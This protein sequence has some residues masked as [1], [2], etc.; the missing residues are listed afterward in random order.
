MAASL[1][2][3]LVFIDILAT[4]PIEHVR[5]YIWAEVGLFG[6][7]LL[8]GAEFDQILLNKRLIHSDVLTR[9]KTNLS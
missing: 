1:V 6:K 5:Y 7:E 2:M 4:P 9:R 8:F 3:G